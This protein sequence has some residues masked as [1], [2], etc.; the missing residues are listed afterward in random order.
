MF[1]KHKQMH[2]SGIPPT[3]STLSVKPRAQK[4]N[5]TAKRN[6][7]K[8]ST[9]KSKQRGKPEFAGEP[10][11]TLQRYFCGGLH[12]SGFPPTLIFFHA[13]QRARIQ[14]NSKEVCSK[15]CTHTHN[16]MKLK[17]S[18]YVVFVFLRSFCCH[19]FP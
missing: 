17:S 10:T 16:G 8:N 2:I 4:F 14:C 9:K 19:L 18:R 3:Q 13:T 5:P 1:G 6:L 15:P 7:T 11:G 12:L